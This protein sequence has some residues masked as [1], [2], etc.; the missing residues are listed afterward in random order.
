LHKL[1]VVLQDRGL[2]SIEAMRLCPAKAE[3]HLQITG[4]ACLVLGARVFGNISELSKLAF[5]SG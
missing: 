2:A 1:A 5:W 3:A 4:L